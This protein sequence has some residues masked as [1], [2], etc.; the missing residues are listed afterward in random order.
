MLTAIP[1]PRHRDIYPGEIVVTLDAMS[2]DDFATSE[3]CG[4]GIRVQHYDALPEEDLRPGTWGL[5]SGKGQP[6]LLHLADPDHGAITAS[7]AEAQFA[8]LASLCGVALARELHGAL[9]ALLGRFRSGDG[10]LCQAFQFTDPAQ[11]NDWVYS[12]ARIA[13]P[14]VNCQKLRT[15]VLESLLRPWGRDYEAQ[16]AWYAA[17]GPTEPEARNFR[18]L[19]ADCRAVTTRQIAEQAT[20]SAATAG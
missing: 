10:A 20:R 11:Y 1:R 19:A 14:G 12:L 2:D 13:R 17:H 15:T 7:F 18:M 4:L 3:P 6:F 5:L 9:Q 8:S 16:A